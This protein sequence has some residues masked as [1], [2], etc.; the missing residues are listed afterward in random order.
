MI[1]LTGEEDD[2]DDNVQQ[3]GDMEH[4]REYDD[5]GDM[6]M[7]SIVMSPSKRPQVSEEERKVSHNGVMSSH[8]V[9]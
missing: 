6:S 5:V 1:P 2:E 3:D 9:T 8:A 4:V 7:R